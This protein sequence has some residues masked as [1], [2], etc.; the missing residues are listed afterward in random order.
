M[1]RKAVGEAAASSASSQISPL[2]GIAQNPQMWG[3]LRDQ[4]KLALSSVYKGFAKQTSLP[5]EKFERL[6]NLMA[7]NVMT[8]IHH[9]T[10]C[11]R[12]GKTTEEMEQ[13]FAQEERELQNQVQ[14]LLGEE[15]AKQFKE[16]T[17]HLLS[18]VTAEQVKSMLQGD[19]KAKDA[20][21]LQLR[22]ILR[23]E[24]QKAL[25]QAGLTPEYQTIPTLNF[26]NFA[27]EQEAE[28]N[29]ELLDTIYSQAQ[30][31]A[32]AF[33][34]PEEVEKFG[35]FRKMAINNNRMALALNRKL[36]APPGK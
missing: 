31:R 14:G 17:G 5:P 19:Q 16:Y 7:D 10:A 26:R 34:K 11:L 27:S 13:V 32:A 2:G 24:S 28:R 35:E 20:A 6:G 23:D 15:G 3:A 12:D 25:L 30:T 29:L 18:D 21:A 33:L 9:I 4:Q 22:D 8:N 36:M 1:L